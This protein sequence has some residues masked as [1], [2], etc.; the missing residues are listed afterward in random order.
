MLIQEL[1]ANGRKRNNII[2]VTPEH[3][4]RIK[5]LEGKRLRWV[6]VDEPA[7]LSPDIKSKKTKKKV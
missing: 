7:T 1:H 2:D 6:P 5:Q 4:E 3:Y